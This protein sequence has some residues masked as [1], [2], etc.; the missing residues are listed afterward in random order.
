LQQ[1]ENA[2][3]RK[4]FTSNNIIQRFWSHTWKYGR[5][6]SLA[7]SG[8]PDS[9]EGTELMEDPAEG[10]KLSSTKPL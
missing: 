8:W 3:K 2:S 9:N 10:Y 4:R 1:L 5:K 7:V 6:A